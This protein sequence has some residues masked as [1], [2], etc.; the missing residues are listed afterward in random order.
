MRTLTKAVL[1]AVLLLLWSCGS[2]EPEAAPT[3]HPSAD[4]S[5]STMLASCVE[6]YSLE[7]LENRDYAFDGTV[8]AIEPGQA[9]ADQADRV[10]F[11][12]TEWFKGGSGSSAI[13]QAHGFAAVTS[14]GGSPHRVGERLLV[15]GD[16]DFVWECGFTQRYDAEVAA[17][18]D[19]R[20]S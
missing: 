10:T 18:W 1:A 17:D 16:D 19:E 3:S 13:R 11:D 14:A 9:A 8:M 4:G 20:L 2:S 12:V 7:T 5:T 15:A 6:R